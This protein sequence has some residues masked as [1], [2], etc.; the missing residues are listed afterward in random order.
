MSHEE[1]ISAQLNVRPTQVAA[2]IALLDGGATLPFIARYRKEATGSLDEEQIRHIEA[3]S[4]RLRALDERRAA[5]IASVTEQ[6]AMTPELAA[7]LAA[8]ETLHALEDLY[9]PYKPKR[10][11]RATIAR[12]RGLGPLADLILAQPATRQAAA[13]PARPLVSWDRDQID[14]AAPLVS[15]YSP[16]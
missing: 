11:T 12:E 9:A 14:R 6:G 16:E 13:E 15:A 5:V 3:E 8:A 2:V 4:A 7:Q 1:R 10:R